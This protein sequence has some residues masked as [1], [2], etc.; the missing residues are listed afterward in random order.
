MLEGQKVTH[1]MG[2]SR[3]RALRKGRRLVVQGFTN[4][5]KGFVFYLSSDAGKCI[6]QRRVLCACRPDLC[7]PG[8]E[9]GP[10]L[11]AI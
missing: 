8:E 9:A 1:K 6:S 5:P 3:K 2:E 4:E 11:G 10:Q 7:V